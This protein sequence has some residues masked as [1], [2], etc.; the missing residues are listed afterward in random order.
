MST[1]E[2]IYCGCSFDPSETPAEH[3]ILNA[4]GGK[5]KSKEVVCGTC[6][7]FFSQNVDKEM[8]ESLG[9]LRAIL[10][11]PRSNP[12][13]VKARG[14]Q[15][16][17]LYRISANGRKEILD[18]TV[19]RP[20]APPQSP[21]KS[22][23]RIVAA[24]DK[25]RQIVEGLARKHPAFEITEIEGTKYSEPLR[26]AGPTPFGGS[27]ERR[28]V[29]KMALNF[30]AIAPGSS[31]KLVREPCFDGIRQFIRHGK[32]HI[33]FPAGI[34]TRNLLELPSIP[35]DVFCNRSAVWCN[36]ET[37][38]AVGWVEILSS[39]PY[40][41]LLSDHYE[42][43]CVGAVICN[44][45]HERG[46]D[47][48]SPVERFPSIETADLLDRSDDAGWL[49]DVEQTTNSLLERVAAYDERRHLQMIAAEAM[50]K[51][52][53]GGLT[54]ES[55]GPIAEF[56]AEKLAEGYLFDERGVTRAYSGWDEF[57]ETLGEEEVKE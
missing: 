40:S 50:K 39:L 55:V 47:M 25:A 54:P 10:G 24:P 6:N 27:V 32:E 53:S 9:L 28:C 26:P 4:F 17:K 43:P 13:T 5:R 41:V 34:D 42:G 8:P 16:G 23:R 18:V 49:Q 14:A 31:V 38:S 1:Q 7:T 51:F 22:P 36:P 44:Y 2:C 37:R 29:A 46:P 48:V 33:K 45:P 21:L 19:E 35:D 30:L 15:T 52:A 57:L 56:V 20:D 12:P 11:V 3:V